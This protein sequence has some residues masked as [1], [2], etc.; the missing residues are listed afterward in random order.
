M[1]PVAAGSAPVAAVASGA[2]V[3]A[4]SGASVG[5]SVAAAAAGAAVSAAAVVGA[6]VAAEDA[7]EVGAWVVGA[8]PPHA[9]ITNVHRT[10]NQ[11]RY[12][13]FMFLFPFHR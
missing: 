2:E 11:I 8:P 7:S 3:A 5:A 6:V 9:A 1:S 13:P 12:N 4:V 10:S